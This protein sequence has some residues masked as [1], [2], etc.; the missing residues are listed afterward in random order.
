MSGSVL[1]V[2]ILQSL[3][4]YRVYSVTESLQ[5]QGLFSYRVYPARET[6]ASAN[7]TNERSALQ[8]PPESLDASSVTCSTASL[9][10]DFAAL[11]VYSEASH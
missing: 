3:F 8:S 5:L 1:T 6:L 7:L 9:I 11:S 2:V 4:S 10:L